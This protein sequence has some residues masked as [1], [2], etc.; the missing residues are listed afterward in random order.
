MYIVYYRHV[1]MYSTCA[2]A[3][4]VY[5]LVYISWRL[6]WDANSIES[7]RQLS[8]VHSPFHFDWLFHHIQRV[9]NLI[10]WG[11]RS[12]VTLMLIW[13]HNL[14]ESTRQIY[15]WPINPFLFK[16]CSV[17][18]SK[19]YHAIYGNWIIFDDFKLILNSISSH[20]T[21]MYVCVCV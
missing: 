20:N 21:H 10:A 12:I 6:S 11:Y 14:A 19:S 7:S 13:Q 15:A 1:Y 2:Y 5:H 16:F 9:L 8:C 17:Y 18:W 3:C 4:C